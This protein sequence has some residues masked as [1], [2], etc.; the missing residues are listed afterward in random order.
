M[1]AEERYEGYYRAP[2]PPAPE[3]RYAEW[4]ARAERTVGVGSVIEA[5]AGSGGFVQ[6]ALRRGWHAE[7]SEISKTGLAVLEQTGA[8]VH[9]GSIEDAGL[10]ERR[11]DLGVSLEVL[12]HLPDPM[13]HLRE[14]HRLLRPGGL[15]LLSTP[16]FDG[17]SRRLLGLRWRVVAGEHI[18]YFTPR[19]LRRSLDAAGFASVELATRGLDIT[20]WRRGTHQRPVT[21][22]PHRT[23]ELR[24]RIEGSSSLRFIKDGVNRLLR[25]SGLGDT[26]LVWAVA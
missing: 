16:N 15:L 13:R 23:A 20:S 8:V 4:L 7:A 1:P 24:H 2:P 6:A 9:R 26:L 14:F 22:D 12:E 17:L 25:V 18:G 5:G 19:T 3:V 21:F 11:F 10:A